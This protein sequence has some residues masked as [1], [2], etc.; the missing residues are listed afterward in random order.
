MELIPIMA[1][2]RKSDMS[3]VPDVRRAV[4]SDP[5]SA[6]RSWRDA[7]CLSASTLSLLIA[8]GSGAQAQDQQDAEPARAAGWQ[9]SA[10]TNAAFTL[11]DNVLLIQLDP[12]SDFITTLTAGV[13]VFNETRGGSID[14]DY[15][16]NYDFYINTDELNGFRHN[17]LTQNTFN[18]VDDLLF[19][20]VNASVREQAASRNLRTPATTRTINGDQ[21][22]VLTGAI[23]PYIDTTIAGRVGV[24][25]RVDYSTV[26]FRRPDVSG[27]SGSGDDDT[28]WSGNFMVNEL[29]QDKRLHW[30]FSGQASAD[31]DNFEQQGASAALRFNVRQNLKL[32]TRGGYDKSSGRLNGFDVDDVFWRVGFEFEPVRDA[33]IRL[34]AG[35]RYGGPS[36]DALIRYDVAKALK[37]NASFVQKL[38]TDQDRIIGMVND[39][40]TVSNSPFVGIRYEDPNPEAALS[41]GVVIDDELISSS[42]LGETA[43][44][45]LTGALGRVGYSLSGYY[46]TREYDL[47]LVSGEVLEDETTGASFSL[48]RDFGRRTSA[49]LGVQYADEESNYTDADFA[50]LVTDFGDV[51]AN[52]T[53]NI[54]SITGNAFVSYMLSPTAQVSLNYSRSEREDQDGVK[55]EE[56]AFMLT[57]TKV[58]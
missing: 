16:L 32:L 57:I 55:V 34:E 1:S 25:A 35:E 49:G 2:H 38:Q 50:F 39:F 6:R 45:T 33:F 42:T 10:N 27:S 37:I 41:S 47:I 54:D 44:V 8:L 3:A 36:Y 31:D 53:N 7:L 15:Q 52:L 4:C 56:N 9:Y 46:R 23:A 30:E 13:Q 12:E 22:M 58:W 14:F 11:T 17:L 40:I 48:S 51:A 28:I 29:D 21:I 19:L 5:Q 18:L 26:S 24:F 43:Q 20:D